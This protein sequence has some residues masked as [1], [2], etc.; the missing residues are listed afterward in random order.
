[1]RKCEAADLRTL[2][3]ALRREPVSYVRTALQLAIKRILSREWSLPAE[4][5]GEFEIPRDT[6]T[7]IEK[8]AVERVTGQLLHEIT[9]LVGLIATSARREVRAYEGSETQRH[10]GSL[11]GVLEA[12]EQLKRATTLPNPT[13]FDLAE[14]LEDL[15]WEVVGGEA[16]DVSL[17]G[18]RPTLISSDP[19]L[20][21][22]AVSNGMR[23]AVEAVTSS[24]AEEAHSIVVTWGETDVDYWV[25]VLDRGPGLVGPV[26]SAFG[27]GQS[28]KKGHS[29]FGLAI[30]R[31]AIE[32][33]GGTCTLERAL[34]GGA[35]FELRWER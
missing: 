14:W 32:T 17:Q 35:W 13:E 1:M 33:L 31:Q 8:V 24:E 11:K 16:V 22:L 19:A 20:L 21:R 29:G 18:A 4:A 28:S 10:V 12:I 2:N 6:R 34:G 26:E 5:S 25:A 30:A 3:E 7:Q 15:V 23:N 27:V 9:P